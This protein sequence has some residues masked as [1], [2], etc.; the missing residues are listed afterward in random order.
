MSKASLPDPFISSHVW[1]LT[2]Q[3]EGEKDWEERLV[4][5]G[6]TSISRFHLGLCVLRECF[7]TFGFEYRSGKM[8]NE[9]AILCHE[10]IFLPFVKVYLFRFGNISSISKVP[11][12]RDK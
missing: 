11:W 3:D 9:L 10:A 7:L 2:C 8:V 5:Y 6:K 1:K 12:T 4:E